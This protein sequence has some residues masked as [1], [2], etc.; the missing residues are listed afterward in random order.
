MEVPLHIQRSGS[1]DPRPHIW[2]IW[3]HTI[4]RRIQMNPKGQEA[5]ISISELSIDGTFLVAVVG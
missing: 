3:V 5:R 4:S 1:S 2:V